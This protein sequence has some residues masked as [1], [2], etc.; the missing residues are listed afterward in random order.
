MHLHLYRLERSKNL[1]RP[2]DLF[3]VEYIIVKAYPLQMFFTIVKYSGR[4]TYDKQGI[5]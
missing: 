1:S 3:A 2:Q 5:V 4:G